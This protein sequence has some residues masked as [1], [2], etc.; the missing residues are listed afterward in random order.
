[1]YEPWLRPRAFDLWSR[2]NRYD[3]LLNLSDVMSLPVF[4]F[5]K[6]R[7]P[8]V[9]QYS[10]G[11]PRPFKLRSNN[12]ND[13]NNYKINCKN[14]LRCDSKRRLNPV[15]LLTTNKR[16]VSFFSVCRIR[17][18]SELIHNYSWSLRYWYGLCGSGRGTAES[19]FWHSLLARRGY[20]IMKPSRESSTCS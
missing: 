1:M 8:N 17:I 2:K 9:V 16:R 20:G 13:N 10:L 15:I 11:D 14:M 4:F 3:C 12:N 5:F 7:K 19:H 18:T 6:H